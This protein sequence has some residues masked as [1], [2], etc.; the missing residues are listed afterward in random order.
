MAC[1]N[2]LLRSLVSMGLC[3]VPVC[4]W[5]VDRQDI[6]I[7]PS[8]KGARNTGLASATP[9]DN[10]SPEVAAQEWQ[11]SVEEWTRYRDL[12]QGR[13]RFFAADM[14]PLL[15]LAM[16][17]E[18]DEDRNHYAEM[19][20]QYERDRADRILKVQRAYDAAMNRLYPNEKIIDLNLLRQQ[21]MHFGSASSIP[22]VTQAAQDSRTPR[23]GDTLALFASADC[24]DCADKIRTLVSRYSIA[25]V[26]VYFSGDSTA[27]KQWLQQSNLQPDWLKQHGVTFARDEGQSQ[28]YQAAPGTAFI[29]RDRALLEMML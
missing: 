21:G 2:G 9:W 29:V 6:H 4:T 22:G 11:L 5:A 19:L 18:N 13:A 17:A 1:A 7:Q 23:I 25:P 14:P 12:M 16:Y 24:A 20:A 10:L 15:V 8:D 26:E 27:F 28:Q 3:L